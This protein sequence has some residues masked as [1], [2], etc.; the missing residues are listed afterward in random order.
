MTED[1]WRRGT[2]VEKTGGD[3]RFEGRIMAIARTFGGATRIIVED[4]RGLLFIFRPAQLARC[5]PPRPPRR[6]PVDEGPFLPGLAPP[7]NGAAGGLARAARLDPDRRSAIA[8]QA[9]RARWQ[10]A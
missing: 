6:E 7:A 5:K 2:R 9:A 3:Y 4:D 8:R 10:A 1:G